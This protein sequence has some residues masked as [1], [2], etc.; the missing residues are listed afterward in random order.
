[1]KDLKNRKGIIKIP[2]QIIDN[3]LDILI[4]CF[5]IVA[6]RFNCNKRIKQNDK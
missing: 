1:M 4:K 3:D 6:T 5:E 2:Q